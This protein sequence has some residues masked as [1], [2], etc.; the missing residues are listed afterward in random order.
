MLLTNRA[1]EAITV[2]LTHR[3]ANEAK[4]SPIVAENLGTRPPKTF[5]E[6]KSALNQALEAFPFPLPGGNWTDQDFL[7]GFGI[8][9]STRLLRTEVIRIN[10]SASKLKQKDQQS[11]EEVAEFLSE[12]TLLV[13]PSILISWERAQFESFAK[14]LWELHGR[15]PERDKKEAKKIADE[16]EASAWAVYHSSENLATIV[17]RGSS[18]IQDYL[19]KIDWPE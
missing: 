2:L 3:A 8:N 19:G 17:A 4:L 10:N 6:F 11:R 5:A 14:E 16:F 13:D 7:H 18:L 1:T 15:S 9:A 12:A